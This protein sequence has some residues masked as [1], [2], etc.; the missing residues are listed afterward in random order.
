MYAGGEEEEEEEEGGLPCGGRLEQC[1]TIVV[2]AEGTTE[3][4]TKTAAVR[5]Y[6][7]TTYFQISSLYLAL[8]KYT[9]T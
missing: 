3:R 8:P 4:I 2:I 9:L 5:H 7:K 6:I 1:G